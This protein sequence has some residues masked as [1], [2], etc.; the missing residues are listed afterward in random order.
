LAWTRNRTSLDPHRAVAV[1]FRQ[2]IGVELG[3]RARQALLD[4]RRDRLALALLLRAEH[5]RPVDRQQLR[6]LVRTLDHAEQRVGDQ[7]AVLFVPRHLAHHQQ[8]RMPQ[9]HDLACLDGE[10][11]DAIGRDP[12]H[13]R[14]DAVGNRDSVLV[15]LV[16][17]QQAVHQRAPQLH[18][19]RE[20]LARAPSCVKARTSLFSLTMLASSGVD[21]G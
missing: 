4:L 12:R 3:E 1:V 6:H 5:I 2:L 11:G 8:R 17:P 13:Q 16:L 14:L 15:E 19:R 10:C 21:D 7:P 9:L 18:L 20:R